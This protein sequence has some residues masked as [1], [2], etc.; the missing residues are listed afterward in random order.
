[1]SSHEPEI[2]I[3]APVFNEAAGIHQ[4]VNSW[5]KVLEE[6][7]QNSLWK[8]YEIIL[9]DD[10]SSDETPLLLQSLAHLN[11][12]ITLIQNEFNM[13][14]G[15]SLNRAI[16]NSKSKYLVL[17]DSDGQFEPSQIVDMF[18]KLD[19]F[20]AVC[21]MRS[22]KSSLTH[23]FASRASTK[24]SNILLGAKVPD[25]NC[26]LKIV[27]GDFLRNTSLRS[28]RM[29]YSGEITFLVQRSDLSSVW[30]EIEHMKRNTGKS[31]SKFVKD[32][33]SRFLFISYLGLE[34]LLVEKNIIEPY[35]EIFKGNKN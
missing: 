17:M 9:C 31:N 18:K 35:T 2:G 22:K 1:M 29:N 26:Q 7:V 30:M 16:K 27:P 20:D 33:L 24:Y 19:S 14:A 13:G 28:T 4:V 25:F 10:G 8:D 3:V 15:S 11:P 21:G 32:G 12:H 34:R 6:G 23:R 5:V